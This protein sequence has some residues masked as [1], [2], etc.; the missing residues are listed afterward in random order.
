M[1]M[2][3]SKKMDG[4]RNIT[5]NFKIKEFACKDG[6]DTIYLD[7][8]LARILQKIR[9]HFGKPVVITSAYRTVAYNKRVGGSSSSYHTKGQAA[10]IKI[11]GVSAVEVAMYAQTITNGVG[12]YYYDNTE[13]VHVDT[14]NSNKHWL[15]GKK[16]INKYFTKSF[17]PTIR[18]GYN[19]NEKDAAVRMLQ[20]KL[21]LRVDGKFGSGTEK[22]VKDF[23]KEH[24]LTVDGIV[25]RNTWNKLF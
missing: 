11:E 2:K 21:G 6:S 19:A 13:F 5:T 22:A 24:N 7:S 18:R 15:C 17:M 25:G 10:D 14:R 8:N 4:N 12:C 23:Q 1:I 3:Y 16:G 9:E 20:K